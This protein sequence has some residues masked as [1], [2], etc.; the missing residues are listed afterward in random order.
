MKMDFL[1]QGNSDSNLNSVSQI[2]AGSPS[3]DTRETNPTAEGTVSL[4]FYV[5]QFSELSL[6]DF[7]SKPHW[8]LGRTT[9]RRKFLRSGTYGSS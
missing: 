1:K 6:I 8:F 4:H 5:I 9:G 7:T 2:M 3:R